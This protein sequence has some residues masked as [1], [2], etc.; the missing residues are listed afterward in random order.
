MC[1]FEKRSGRRKSYSLIDRSSTLACVIPV[2]EPGPASSLPMLFSSASISH[3]ERV[4]LIPACHLLSAPYR[5]GDRDI[6]SRA[7]RKH[8]PQVPCSSPVF[9]NDEP[10]P[11]PV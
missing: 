4:L 3:C 5:P 10:G 1:S 2:D 6:E 9:R 7:D 8:R 11:V